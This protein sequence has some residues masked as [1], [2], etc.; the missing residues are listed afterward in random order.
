MDTVVNAITSDDKKK[1]KGERG[2]IK[3][4]EFLFDNKEK[5]E[6]INQIFS[7]NSRIQLRNPSTNEIIC[8][9]ESIEKSSAYCKA[10]III[11]FLDVS[12]RYNVSIK[13]KDGASPTLLNHTPL[14]A[15]CWE[16][17]R[18][19]KDVPDLTEIIRGLICKRKEGMCKEDICITDMELD[20][21]KKN[22]LANVI[23]Y[24]TFEGTGSKESKCPANSVLFVGNSSNV[25]ETCEFTVCETH[26]MKLDYIN[27]ILPRLKLSLRDKGMP[28]EKEKLEKCKPWI[29]EDDK[30]GKLKG[31]LHIRF[32]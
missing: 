28:I 6:I 27:K 11:D 17:E 26:E 18:L 1:N 15:K 9:K 12:K 3:T 7:I 14:S 25:S 23:S 22:T 30:K 13:C 10:D 31:A 24:F 16:T 5:K 21:N 32:R 20:E 2:E 8:A 29:Y 19:K 4:I